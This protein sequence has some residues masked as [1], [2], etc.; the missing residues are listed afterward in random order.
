MNKV[1]CIQTIVKFLFLFLIEVFNIFFQVKNPVLCPNHHVFC[2]PCMDVWLQKNKQCPACRTAM[3]A[4]K[5]IL[6]MSVRLSHLMYN[7]DKK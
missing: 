3:T 6:G 1:I 5:K 4:G 7:F 2:G